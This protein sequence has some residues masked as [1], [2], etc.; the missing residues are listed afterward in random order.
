MTEHEGKVGATWEDFWTKKTEELKEAGI[1]APKER[2][3]GFHERLHVHL[4]IP[5][6]SH[7]C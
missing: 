3:Y 1:A 7:A 5:I 2:K 4:S 6:L